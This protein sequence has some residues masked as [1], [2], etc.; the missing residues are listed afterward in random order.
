MAGLQA[1]FLAMLQEPEDH[2]D[3][4]QVTQ[5]RKRN[6]NDSDGHH[7]GK[8]RGGDDDADGEEV[9]QKYAWIGVEVPNPNSRNRASDH[10]GFSKKN[11]CIAMGIDEEKFHFI[12]VGGILRADCIL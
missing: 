3:A 5:K 2:M 9:A 4:T 12:Q 6:D 8:T 1:R 10:S 11:V 7:N